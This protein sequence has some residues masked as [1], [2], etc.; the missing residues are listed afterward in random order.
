MC[1]HFVFPVVCGDALPARLSDCEGST[2]GKLNPFAGY[3][4][5]F[6]LPMHKGGNCMRPAIFLDRDGVI[7]EN[8]EDYVRSWDDV[9]FIE[10]A[11]R[12]LRQVAPLDVAVV[13]VTNQAGVGKGLIT[14]EEAERINE[15]VV[16]E[17]RR[18]GGRIDRAY[19]CPHASD[20]DCDCRKPKPGMLLRA[21]HDLDI[22]LA[23]SYM[24][25]DAITDMQAAQAAGVEG[26]IVRTGRGERELA[27]H[28]GEAWFDIADD[29]LDAFAAIQSLRF[30]A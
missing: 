14:L 15:R 30:V 28:A 22:D 12:A 3:A 29:L 13:V 1:G 24:V 5:Q 19:L 21:A 17:V 16:H 23:H 2:A 10:P 9:C 6:L 20:V 7:I 25:G 8:C 11:I 4:C 26:V 27:R 18:R